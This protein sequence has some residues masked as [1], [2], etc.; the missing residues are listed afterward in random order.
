MVHKLMGCHVLLGNPTTN[1]D[2]VKPGDDTPRYI[3]YMCPAC[4]HWDDGV[5]NAFEIKRNSETPEISGC[6]CG[7]YP[8]P[9]GVYLKWKPLTK[10]Q[11]ALGEKL[12]GDDPRTAGADDETLALL[13]N[14]NPDAGGATVW[15][16]QWGGDGG[17][18][19]LGALQATA[20]HVGFTSESWNGMDTLHETWID[21]KGWKNDDINRG[22]SP[23]DLGEGGGG[24]SAKAAAGL[25]DKSPVW[26]SGGSEPTDPVE[27]AAMHMHFANLDERARSDCTQ[28]Q[29][30]ELSAEERWA[31]VQLGVG[32]QALWDAVS[33]PVSDV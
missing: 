13:W 17:N 2:G 12:V 11:Q 4:N 6:G 29:W 20:T 16:K 32:R 31:A 7:C 3:A 21:G 8:P 10:T 26:S 28:K 14:N 15:W 25:V 9:M 1:D 23:V 24:G 27:D 5:G 18:M 30:R 22:N 33:D 19:G